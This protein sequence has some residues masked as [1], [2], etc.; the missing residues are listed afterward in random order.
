M[1]ARVL[2]VDDDPLKTEDVTSTIRDSFGAGIMVQCCEDA[3]SATAL[4][5]AERFDLIIVDLNLPHRKGEAPASAAGWSLLQRVWQT[6]PA[7]PRWGVCLTAYAGLAEEYRERFSKAAWKLIEYDASSFLWR[8][9]LTSHLQYCVKSIQTEG[10]QYLTDVGIVTALQTPELDA[11]LKLPGNWRQEC[12]TGDGAIYHRTEWSGLSVVAMAAPHMG[13]PAAAVACM[14]L[15]HAYRPRYL[16]MPGITA[17]L[18]GNPGD[19]VIASTAW[20]ASAGKVSEDGKGRERFEPAPQS[21]SLEPAIRARL[22]AFAAD[23]AA[24]AKVPLAWPSA[25]GPFA[26]RLGPNATSATVVANRSMVEEL[27][28]RDRKLEGIE[29]EAFAVFLAAR[30]CSEPRPLAFV[31]KGICDRADSTKNDAHQDYAAFTSA[32]FLYLFATQ[33]LQQGHGSDTR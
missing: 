15:I 23:R 25:C 20:D 8:D 5:Q 31:A 6:L 22:E 1:S 26:A 33:M 2:I 17:G 30:E 12:K 29:M 13:M 18:K 24:C 14:K 21:L 3:T 16:A 10:D 7:T 9:A 28:G 11:V 4:L 27:V 32:Q 19:V